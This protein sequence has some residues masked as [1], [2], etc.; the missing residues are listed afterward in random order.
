PVAQPRAE[1]LKTDGLQ[2]ARWQVDMLENIVRE[3][4]MLQAKKLLNRYKSQ[5]RIKRL[6]DRSVTNPRPADSF[7]L[8]YGDNGTPAALLAPSSTGM[9]YDMLSG[10]TVNLNNYTSNQYYWFQISQ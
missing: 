8:I 2:L 10:T 7:Y 3:P 6:G 4:D 1:G 9:H 5:N